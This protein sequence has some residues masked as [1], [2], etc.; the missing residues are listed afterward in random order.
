MELILIV[1]LM[2]GGMM[3]IGGISHGTFDAGRQAAG[4]DIKVGGGWTAFYGLLILVGASVL[5]IA[6]VAASEGKL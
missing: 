4:E 2:I 5:L 6:L 3:W 1:L